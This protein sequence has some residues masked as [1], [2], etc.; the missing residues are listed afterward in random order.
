MSTSV[1]TEYQKTLGCG[2][3]TL[4]IV[5]TYCKYQTGY[6]SQKNQTFSHWHHPK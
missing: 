6:S 4:I 3:M 2:F 1:L 5:W